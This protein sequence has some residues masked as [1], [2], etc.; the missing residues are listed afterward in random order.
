MLQLVANGTDQLPVGVDPFTVDDNAYETI[1]A[2]RCHPD[3]QTGDHAPAART[4]VH[5]DDAVGRFDG[6]NESFECR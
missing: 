3:G 2:A 1:P 4:R 6:P 5:V